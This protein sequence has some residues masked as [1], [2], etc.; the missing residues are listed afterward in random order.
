[1]D[2]F[3][4]GLIFWRRTPFRFSCFSRPSGP[5]W[6]FYVGFRGFHRIRVTLLEV[7]LFTSFWAP[8]GRRGTGRFGLRLRVFSMYVSHILELFLMTIFTLCPF[9]VRIYTETG[10][11]GRF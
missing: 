10:S 8:A 7:E 3:V 9:E 5:F 2:T 4:P 6:S 11:S 1:L